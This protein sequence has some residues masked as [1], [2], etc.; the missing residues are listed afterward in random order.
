MML[1]WPAGECLALWFQLQPNP[2][3][4]SSW[5]GG[6]DSPPAIV[7]MCQQSVPQAVGLFDYTLDTRSCCRLLTSE[8]LLT[9]CPPQVTPHHLIIETSGLTSG[10]TGNILIHRVGWGFQSQ[11]FQSTRCDV[12]RVTNCG[13]LGFEKLSQWRTL[14]SIRYLVERLNSRHIQQGGRWSQGLLS[15]SPN[16]L[17]KN[18]DDSGDENSGCDQGWC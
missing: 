12:R 1:P 6:P 2:P 3:A 4:I 17:W 18:A 5:S 8:R 10:N 9:D 16:I 13:H 7:S 15:Y 11:Q 14:I